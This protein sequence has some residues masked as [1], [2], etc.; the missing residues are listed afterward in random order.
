MDCL[1]T[2]TKSYTITVIPQRHLFISC[3]CH[4]RPTFVNQNGNGK[5]TKAIPFSK[6]ISRKK[7]MDSPT[8]TKHN[9]CWLGVFHGL[10]PSTI[11]SEIVFVL[12]FSFLSS[13][14]LCFLPLNQFVQWPRPMSV[15]WVL[16]IKNS[17]MVSNLSTFSMLVFCFLF[18]SCIFR[19]DAHVDGSFPPLKR[20]T[21]Y[22]QRERRSW[23]RTQRKFI[24][25][26]W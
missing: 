24:H 10:K 18:S 16:L 25:G 8:S 20:K 13:S 17:A 15:S 11:H 19:L 1:N 2:V 4:F 14:V 22:T 3:S 5:N 12:M 6:K 9:I 26:A 23:A 21:E 7:T